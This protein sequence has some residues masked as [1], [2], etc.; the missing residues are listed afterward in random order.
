MLHNNRNNKET[1]QK[2]NNWSDQEAAFF[3][4][5]QTNALDATYCKPCNGEK[6]GPTPHHDDDDDGAPTL[7]ATTIPRGKAK[8]TVALGSSLSNLSKS[9]KNAFSR[10][11]KEGVH[12]REDSRTNR[13][14][15]APNSTARNNAAIDAMTRDQKPQRQGLPQ[16][17]PLFQTPVPQPNTNSDENRRNMSRFIQNTLVSQIP[18][19][20]THCNSIPLMFHAHPFFGATE[21][22]CSTHSLQSVT[23]CVSCCRFEPKNHPFTQIGTSSAKICSACARTAILDDIA[24]RELY[25]NVL[26]FMETQGLDMFQGKMLNIPVYLVDE[27]GMNM[28]S[29][30]IGCNSNEQKRGLTIW[31]EQHVPIP[32]IAGIARSASSAIL[33][34]VATRK[35]DRNIVDGRNENLVRRNIWNGVRSV[36]VQKILCLKGLPSNLMSSI[37]AH[38]ATHAWLAFC[39]IR[40]DGVIGEE[41]TFGQVRRIDQMVEEGLCQLVAHLYLQHLMADDRKEGLLEG[42]RSDCPSDAK[43][44]QYYK[45]SIE[46][47]ASPIY[48]HGFKMAA[49][50]YSQT[51]QSGG[52]LKDL[53]EYVSM[54]RDFP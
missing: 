7:S 34:I 16:I 50:A 28:Q 31:S 5:P 54:H 8:K 46:N 30:T 36:S 17:P 4:L 23:R 25:E 47:H 22:I 33:G 39:P 9:A 2:G 12:R 49:Q 44:N 43:L 26:S 42:F 29:S 18:M 41:T 13:T 40:R 11:T 19:R 15:A 24:A 21:R 48:G 14:A 51:V 6:K 38:E 45:W 32:D 35:Q 37:L 3:D 53:F 1:K 10:V 20:C 52:S 27:N